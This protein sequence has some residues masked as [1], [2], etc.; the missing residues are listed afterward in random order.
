MARKRRGSVQKQSANK[1]EA[2][3]YTK[4]KEVMMGF[5]EE[6]KKKAASYTP[7]FEVLGPFCVI[8]LH[9]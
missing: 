3:I 5:N 6:E 8:L 1:V 9:I 2:D 7:L 4:M